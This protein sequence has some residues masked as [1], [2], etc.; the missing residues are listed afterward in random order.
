MCGCTCASACVERGFPSHL[1]SFRTPSTCFNPVLWR[2]VAQRYARVWVL[3]LAYWVQDL[4]SGPCRT[5]LSLLGS[6][7]PQP[8]CNGRIVTFP[9]FPPGD[10]TSCASWTSQARFPTQTHLLYL[11]PS[12]FGIIPQ[13]SPGLFPPA[14]SHPARLP[15]LFEL[16]CIALHRIFLWCCS[17]LLSSSLCTLHNHRQHYTTHTRPQGIMHLHPHSCQFVH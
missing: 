16:A 10:A 3:Q 1:T 4:A 15:L 12:S 6:R 9:N 8:I 11:H 17:V 13:S 2:A 5:C 7:C 14:D